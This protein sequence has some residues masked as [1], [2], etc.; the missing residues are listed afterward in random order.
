MKLRNRTILLVCLLLVTVFLISGCSGEKSP[1][2]INNDASYNV[3]VKYDANGGFF[4]TN[5]SVIMDSFNISGMTTNN[6]GQVEIPLIAP[7]DA[8]RGKEGFTPVKNGYF[9]AG[10]YAERTE[11]TDANG[12][13]IYTYSNKWDFAKDKLKVHANGSYSAQE[14][15][16]T[17]YA[18]WVPLF[19][20]EFYS[21]NSDEVLTKMTFDPN[22]ISGITVPAWDRTTGAIDMNDFPSKEGYTFNG[23]YLDKEGSQAVTDE[24]IVHPGTVNYEN[25][26]SSNSTMKLYVDW[27]EGEWFHIYTA[28]QFIKNAKLSGNYVIHED[29]DFEGQIW[30]T[31][32]MHGVFTGSIQGNGHTFK[33]VSATQ[34]NNSKMVSGLFGQIKDSAQISDLTFDNATFTIKKGA[35]VKGASFG[36]LAGQIDD[37][38][39]LSGVQLINSALLIDSDCA[40]LF[41]DY[42]IGLICGT[43]NDS[44]ILAPGLVCKPTGKAPES[45]EITVDGN[46]VRVEKVSE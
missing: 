8:N 26:T 32:F 36:L 11:S 23:V 21:V 29:L 30:P 44:G 18:A 31:A 12:E 9:L 13:K 40:F 43:G 15:V 16:L 46:A 1:Y 34:T 24:I 5:T 19:E 42:A 4:T 27:M 38:A 6:A 39:K 7:N 28:E 22:Q 45:L 14:P 25:G 2:D 17:L 33:N 3:S 35:R 10:W 20:V 37:N 41:D